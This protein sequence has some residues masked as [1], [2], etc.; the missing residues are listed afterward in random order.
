[1]VTC[2][3]GPGGD[4]LRPN[5]GG[6]A[7]PTTNLNGTIA[8][9]DVWRSEADEGK[10]ESRTL[11]RELRGGAKGEHSS[12]NETLIMVLRPKIG[13]G[14]GPQ[15]LGSTPPASPT[16]ATARPSTAAR[17]VSL[18]LPRSSRL[19]SVFAISSERDCK[20]HHLIYWLDH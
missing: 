5:E 14:D 10:E 8:T 12:F 19:D 1:M 13:S 15:V 4:E 6:G 7:I 20:N 2:S 3:G 9:E 16:T 11:A 17:Q 18:A